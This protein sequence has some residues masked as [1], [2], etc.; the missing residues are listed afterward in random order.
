M[1][2]RGPDRLTRCSEQM[3]V[4]PQ[5]RT[6]TCHLSKGD[7]PRPADVGSKRVHATR[8]THQRNA[9]GAADGEQRTAY[10]GRQGDHSHCP[11][12]MSGDICRTAN[13][14]GTLSI[15]ADSTPTRIL[16]TV[17]PSDPYSACDVNV[18]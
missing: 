10:S 16:A 9:G 1:G 11:C 4:Q 2:A 8:L 5:V 13:M 3:S 15:T 14:T 18:R 7:C 6:D 17:A 12:D